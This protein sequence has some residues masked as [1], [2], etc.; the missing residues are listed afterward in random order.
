[1]DA[2]GTVTLEFVASTEDEGRR[3]DVV[4]SDHLPDRSRSQIQGHVRDGRV[5]VNGRA[6][7]SSWRLVA[8][9]VVVASIAPTPERRVRPE[10]VD[11]DLI[12]VD[13][14]VI[15]VRKPAGM[16]VHPTDSSTSGTLVNALLHHFPDIAAV[17]PDPERPGIVHRLDRDTTGLMMVAR[18][19]A[20]HD[21]LQEQLSDRTATRVYAAIVCGSPPDSGSVRAAIG[22]STRDRTRYTVGGD[23]ER[24]AVTH[25]ETVERFGDHF[26]L[27]DVRLET[28]RTHQIRVHLSHIGHPVACDPVYGGGA[29][30]AYR[31]AAPALRP[32]FA[33]MGRQMLH[34]RRLAFVHPRSG[35]VVAFEDDL[36][37]DMLRLASSLRARTP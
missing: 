19:D 7:Q 24:D 5:L 8:G 21:N 1:M 29:R 13:D 2:N 6:R 11:L 10:A 23:R 16:V 32:L 27:L 15:V 25:Y 34:A 18:T 37:D 33:S 20:A 3:L 31:E 9:A 30:R 14:D 4:L 17:G 28:G 26:S 36:P 22:R 35:V 12:H